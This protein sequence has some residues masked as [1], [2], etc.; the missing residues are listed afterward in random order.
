MQKVKHKGKGKGKG[1]GK[2]VKSNLTLEQ[3]R[4][5]LSEIKA[6]SPCMRR[7]AT[8]HWAGDAA[9]KFP[10]A[11]SKP[12]A[13]QPRAAM[14]AYMSDSS[15]DDGD[16]VILTHGHSS[17][18]TAMMGYSVARG[19]AKGA[20]KPTAKPSVPVPL[21]DPIRDQ[22]PWSRCPS[23]SPRVQPRKHPQIPRLRSVPIAEISHSR[24]VLHTR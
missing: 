10:S 5:K 7:G 9:C 1:K 16:C 14:M 12:Q 6:R 17:T 22:L 3:R 19:R 11:G 15:S 2:L 23:L 8:G 18:P 20:P 4:A 13:S 24:G 21:L